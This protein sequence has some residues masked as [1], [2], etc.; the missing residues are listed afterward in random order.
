MR[1]FSWK[2]I[3]LE[4]EVVGVSQLTLEDLGVLVGF[5]DGLTESPNDSLAFACSEETASDNRE[6]FDL[7]GSI[8]D[9]K[10]AEG[11]EERGGINAPPPLTLEVFN[12]RDEVPG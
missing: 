10:V 9:E 6:E 5:A 11:F 2:L 3:L 7:S 12:L 4:V 8:G 1:P